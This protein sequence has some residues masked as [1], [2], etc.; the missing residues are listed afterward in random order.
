M[1][2]KKAGTARDQSFKG[3]GSIDR[4]LNN[5]MDTAF[6]LTTHEENDMLKFINKTGNKDK[7]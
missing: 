4:N 3:A 6:K 5:E 7:D 1:D 2:I